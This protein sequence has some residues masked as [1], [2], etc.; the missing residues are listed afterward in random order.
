VLASL[1]EGSLLLLRDIPVY[2]PRTSP[3]TAHRLVTG[4]L[5]DGVTAVML[6][7]PEPSLERAGELMVGSRCK[8]FKV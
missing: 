1:P 3:D 6:C 2:L 4:T 8:R 5:V 7:G